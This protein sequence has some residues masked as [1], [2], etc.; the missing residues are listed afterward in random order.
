MRKYLNYVLPCMLLTLAPWALA[1]GA[2]EAGK[3]VAPDLHGALDALVDSI[4]QSETELRAMPAYQLPDQQVGAYQHIVS[5]IIKSL[6]E[7][8][9]QDPDYPLFRN[10]DYRIREGGDNADQSYF[11]ARI[12]GG[13]DYRIWGRIGSAQRIAVQLYKGE[14][15]T[16]KG[17]VGG[18]LD[19]ENIKFGADGSFEIFISAR[20]H[21]GNWI[22]TSGDVT[23]VIVRQIY[24]Q[25][26][27][28]YPG[29]IHIDRVG[30]EGKRKPQVSREQMT[31]Q[32]LDAARNVHTTATVWPNFV[33]HKYRDV[34][35]PNT[36]SGLID[37]SGSGGLSGRWMASGTFDLGD[38]EAL[39]IKTWPTQAKYQGIQLCDL[40]FSS[41]EYGNGTSS[42]TTLQSVRAPDGAY[43]YVVAKTDPGA[44]NW[45]DTMGTA[46]GVILLRYDGVQGD[47]SKEKWPSARKVALKD[48]PAVIPGFEQAVTADDRFRVLAERRKHIQV[49]T[50]R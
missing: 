28:D 7:S 13:A 34:H 48:L 33:Q 6:E 41:L 39:V 11:M 30:F 14:P 45:L 36:L 3:N 29:E 19:F 43:Y 8:V 50:N 5:S 38:D 16:G 2:V 25:W 32:L 44:A 1:E 20:Q 26:S 4:K 23:S 40:W 42:L 49:R 27:A 17:G 15:W 37:T 31:A 47:I 22:K 18:Y 46:Q 10:I 35:T 9:V 24:P 12:R 21:E